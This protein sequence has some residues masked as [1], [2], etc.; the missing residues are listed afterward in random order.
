MQA[1]GR[2]CADWWW[3]VRRAGRDVV[4]G[5]IV[6]SVLR[7]AFCVLRRGGEERREASEVN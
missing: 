3:V 1:L 6:F 4:G 5:D 7:S 2:I